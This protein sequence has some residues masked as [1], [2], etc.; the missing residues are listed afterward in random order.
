MQPHSQTSPEKSTLL[1][2]RGGHAPMPFSGGTEHF[3]GKTNRIGGR[4]EDI[5]RET[6]PHARLRGIYLRPTLFMIDGTAT[7]LMEVLYPSTRADSSLFA[8]ATNSLLP[9]TTEKPTWWGYRRPQSLASWVCF[10]YSLTPVS[11]LPAAFNIVTETPDGY[12]EEELVRES[13]HALHPAASEQWL[14]VAQQMSRSLRENRHSAPFRAEECRTMGN[15]LPPSQVSLPLGGD[16]ECLTPNSSALLGDVEVAVRAMR[17][18]EEFAFLIMN[19]KT[20]YES[21]HSAYVSHL[22]NNPGGS[23]FRC[24]YLRVKLLYLLPRVPTWLSV[25]QKYIVDAPASLPKEPERTQMA[26]ERVYNYILPIHIFR[27]SAFCINPS[28]MAFIDTQT[29]Q[30]A[31]RAFFVANASVSLGCH[32]APPPQTGFVGA[33]TVTQQCSSGV[34]TITKGTKCG[35]GSEDVKADAEEGGEKAPTDEEALAF[36]RRVFFASPRDGATVSCTVVQKSLLT[37]CLL[38]PKTVIGMELGSMSLPLWLEASLQT[39]HSGEKDFVSVQQDCEDDGAL[40]C[41]LADE[42]RTAASLQAR[43]MEE[44]R[45]G[46]I[47]LRELAEERGTPPGTSLS[48]LNSFSSIQALH[49]GGS[50]DE[51]EPKHVSPHEVHYLV[52]LDRFANVYDTTAFFFVHPE[53]SLRVVQKLDKEA[54]ALRRMSGTRQANMQRRLE[55][56]D[57]ADHDNT[58]SRDQ[59]SGSNTVEDFALPACATAQQMTIHCKPF[60]HINRPSEERGIVKAIQKMNLIVFFL[61]FHVN[62]RS[63]RARGVPAVLMQERVETLMSAFCRLGRL[64][65][66]LH[67]R[68]AYT[69]AVAALSAAIVLSPQYPQLWMHRGALH[70]RMH[71]VHS[72]VYDLTRA[73]FLAEERLRRSTSSRGTE[74]AGGNREISLPL[75]ATATASTA[76]ADA[77]G[78]GGGGAAE[79]SSGDEV[80]MLWRIIRRAETLLTELRTLQEG[81]GEEERR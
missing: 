57:H 47:S 29:Y 41:S 66:K 12:T 30:C 5:L 34:G 80:T 81:E 67:R 27:Y 61:T 69:L 44:M 78:D 18:G 50:K 35:R 49:N 36:L 19:P 6:S 43:V 4:A 71:E 56:D 3:G 72:A 17:P 38:T 53:N 58:D 20:F 73:K 11:Q 24:V 62:E 22:F 75:F 65:A 46:S 77:A 33:E 16:E 55:T 37:G 59:Y 26:P 54:K 70:Q 60:G 51:S 21:I 14:E 15:P 8:T 13:P 45:G 74:A 28:E 32:L 25:I 64:Y 9:A 68:D 10:E 2:L 40:L 31:L 1:R 42:L 48:S 76:A 23:P 7:H 39:M 52:S 79:D 63:M